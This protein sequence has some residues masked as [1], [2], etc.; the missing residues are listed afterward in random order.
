MSE[1]GAHAVVFEAARG[2]HPFV[3]QMQHAGV[4]THVLSDRIGLLQ[5]CLAFATVTSRD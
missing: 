3:L 2:V 1:R 5:Q 4:Q